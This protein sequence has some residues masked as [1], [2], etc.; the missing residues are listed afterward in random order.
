[1]LGTGERGTLLGPWHVYDNDGSYNGW[2][3]WMPRWMRVGPW[4]PTAVLM[5]IMFYSAVVL[6]RPPMTNKFPI[7]QTDDFGLAADVA[8]IAWTSF[9]VAKSWR[10]YNGARPYVISFTGWSWTLLILRAGCSAAS[11]LLLNR[12]P[13]AVQGFA[14][15]LGLALGIAGSALHFPAFVGAVVTFSI[16][17]LILFPLLYFFAKKRTS[18]MT[19]KQFLRFNFSFFM[20]N[21]HFFNL[22]LACVNVVFG[23]GARPLEDV[24]LWLGFV[25]AALY[26]I[27]YL[28]GLDRLGLHFYPIFN[29]RTAFSGISYGLLFLLYYQIFKLGNYVIALQLG[30][31]APPPPPP[32]SAWWGGIFS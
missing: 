24:D 16:W 15:P 27:V 31:S 5:I 9:V 14:Q 32:A 1:M 11:N 21:I 13:A 4:H 2:F 19:R 25:V 22:P 29:P 30:C 18:F 20:T 23:C 12:S 7:V 26:S 17:N 28:F 3:D 10:R 6:L 8:V